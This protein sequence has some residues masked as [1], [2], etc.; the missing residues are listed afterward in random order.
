MG[1]TFFTKFYSAIALTA[2]FPKAIQSQ[3]D[4][5]HYKMAVRKAS[6]TGRLEI[7]LCVEKIDCQTN[8]QSPV[9]PSGILGSPLL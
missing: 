8:S 2:D 1:F 4:T 6:A 5:G 3:V 7:R 9:K